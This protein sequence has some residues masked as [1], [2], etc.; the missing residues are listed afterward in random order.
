MQLVFDNQY[1]LLPNSRGKQKYVN[2][3]YIRDVMGPKAFQNETDCSSPMH[4]I[5]YQWSLQHCLRCDLS[6]RMSK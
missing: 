2:G 4:H 3:V 5:V 6:T 1:C